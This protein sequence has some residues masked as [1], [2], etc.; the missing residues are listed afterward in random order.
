VLRDRVKE[1]QKLPFSIFPASP[2]GGTA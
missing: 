1:I 2:S